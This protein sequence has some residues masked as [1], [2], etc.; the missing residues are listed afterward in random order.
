MFEIKIDGA[1]KAAL[2]RH[3]AG[4]DCVELTLEEIDGRPVIEFRIFGTDLSRRAMER[5]LALSLTKGCKQFTFASMQFY[6]KIPFSHVKL[7]FD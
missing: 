5:C 6:E 4:E 3:F 1:E 7:Y 2:Y